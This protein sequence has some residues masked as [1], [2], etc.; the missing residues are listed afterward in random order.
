MGMFGNILVL[1]ATLGA[2]YYLGYRSGAESCV[3]DGGVLVCRE[4]EMKNT[5]SG[6]LLSSMELPPSA[7]VGP[8]DAA[9]EYVIGN[10]GSGSRKNSGQKPEVAGYLFTHA[11]GENGMLAKVP[12]FD[13]RARYEYYPLQESLE[14]K[15]RVPL[16]GRVSGSYAG[17]R[18]AMRDGKETA[19]SDSGREEFSAEKYV[20]DKA[21]KVIGKLLE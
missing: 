13:G 11:G 20:W 9:I 12:G 8:R 6:M 7:F 15:V 4:N 5:Q 19:G 18:P 3:T 10:V 21:K 14:S 16:A 17:E 1:G 2:G